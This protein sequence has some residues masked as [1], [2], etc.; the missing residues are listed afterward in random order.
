MSVGKLLGCSEPSE[1][2]S[3]AYQR[4]SW[5]KGQLSILSSQYWVASG[6]LES[7]HTEHYVGSMWQKFLD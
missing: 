7:W 5:A 6:E 4:T 2:L 1:R 3:Y